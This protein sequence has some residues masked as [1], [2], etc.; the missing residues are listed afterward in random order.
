MLWRSV[1]LHLVPCLHAVLTDGQ[2][3]PNQAP[4]RSRYAQACENVDPAQGAACR[5]GLRELKSR[6]G[7]RGRDASPGRSKRGLGAFPLK[8]EAQRAA[9]FVRPVG[10]FPNPICQRPCPLRPNAALVDQ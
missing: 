8:T 7:P 6:S 5:P 1:P 10:R 9:L 4:C 2:W 3:P